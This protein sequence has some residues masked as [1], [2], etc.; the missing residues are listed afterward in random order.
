MKIL[1]IE[2]ATEMCSVA[3]WHDGTVIEHA[4][5]TSQGHSDLI[6]QMASDV[7]AAAHTSLTECDLLAYGD[8]PGSF[9]A[10]RIG[11]GIAQ[12]IGLGA[13]L[14]L[15]G[16]SSLQALAQRYAV[17]ANTGVLSAFD[18]RMGEVYW[19]CFVPGA[20]A[21]MVPLNEAQV[22]PV[23]S[24]ELSKERAWLMVGSG[25]DVYLDTLT[26]RFANLS[27]T[28]IEQ[29]FPRATEVAALAAMDRSKTTTA[30]GAEPRYV[31]NRVAEPQTKANA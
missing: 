3:L 19:C 14:P 21:E 27:L 13:G 17:P 24:I 8:G 28:H 10:L 30:G 1:A 20:D 12:G 9:T 25:V 6:L 31:R 23:A 22:G 4:Q 16:I 11:V 26:K 29:V 7:L 18:A 5:R 15:I 2:T